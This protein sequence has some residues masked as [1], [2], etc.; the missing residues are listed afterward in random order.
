MAR[1]LHSLLSRLLGSCLCPRLQVC[2]VAMLQAAC[3][4]LP[5]WLPVKG[6]KISLNL[7]EAQATQST[8]QLNRMNRFCCL[9]QMLH[10]AL[11]P[12]AVATNQGT[13]TGKLILSQT[14]Q[15]EVEGVGAE[16]ADGAAAV[17]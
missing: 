11:G 8:E 13:I 14:D 12:R 6:H 3:C 4:L 17:H 2:H 10:L 16:G 5:V 7:A 15:E 9:L 1:K